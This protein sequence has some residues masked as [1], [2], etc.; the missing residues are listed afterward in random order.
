MV[1]DPAQEVGFAIVFFFFFRGV[2]ILIFLEV[3]FVWFF[4]VVCCFH[5]F[6]GLRLKTSSLVMG[7]FFGL[8]NVLSI[9][10]GSSTPSGLD[11]LFAEHEKLNCVKHSS[12]DSLFIA[13]RKSFQYQARQTSAAVAGHRK[14][15]GS[16]YRSQ[17]KWPFQKRI[18]TWG[19]K[20]MLFGSP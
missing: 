16:I 7:S 12:I 19:Y 10:K 6:G 17:K 2:L 18:Y 5:F 3:V 15:V 4:R 20:G 9:S 1:V 14:G 13:N 11:Q 8:R